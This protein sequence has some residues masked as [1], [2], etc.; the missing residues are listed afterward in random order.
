MQPNTPEFLNQHSAE[1]QRQQPEGLIGF[2]YDADTD[3]EDTESLVYQSEDVA[4][5][6]KE[7]ARTE[8]GQAEFMKT[9]SSGVRRSL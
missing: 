1:F 7:S 4:R 8:Q 9:P 5:T 3:S 6:A 2:K